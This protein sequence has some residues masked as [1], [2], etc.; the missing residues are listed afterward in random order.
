MCNIEPDTTHLR[1]DVSGCVKASARHDETF[2]VTHVG[3]LQY[4]F[5]DRNIHLLIK[6]A[7]ILFILNYHSIYKITSS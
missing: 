6:N 5:L 2:S 4:I 3:R 7:S 1:T